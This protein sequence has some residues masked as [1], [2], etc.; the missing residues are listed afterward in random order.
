MGAIDD[1]TML[2]DDLALRSDH[3]TIRIDPQAHRSI[4]KGC[5]DAVAI[6]LQM[7]EAGGRDPL[8]IF[9]EAV[10]RAGNRHQRQSLLS[11]DV[12]D[13]AAHLSVWGLCPELLASKLQ[14]VVQGIQ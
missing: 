14:P 5:G 2:A 13:G 11:P 1:A 9:D 6:A 10:E 12:G 4:G 7:D 8:R 3:D